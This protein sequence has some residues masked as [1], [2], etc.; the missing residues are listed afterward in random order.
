VVELDEPGPRHR[1]WQHPWIKVA[2]NYVTPFAVSS[3]AYL[4]ARRRRNVERLVAL[5]G[6]SSG[7]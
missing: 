4:A 7:A 5:L 2:L 1:R 3:L 6:E